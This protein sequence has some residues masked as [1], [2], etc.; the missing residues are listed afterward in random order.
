MQSVLG[1]QSSIRIAQEAFKP[2]KIQN[3][4]YLQDRASSPTILA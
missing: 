2:D 1:P 4:F 3:V